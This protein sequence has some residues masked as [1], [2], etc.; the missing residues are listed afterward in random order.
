M[1][2]HYARQIEKLKRMILSLGKRVEE[3]VQQAIQAIEQR[4]VDLARAVIE[5]DA[6]IDEQEV[7]IEEECLHTLALY[8]PVASDMRFIV[9]VVKINN[10]LERIGDHAA[11]LAEQAIF[12]AREPRIDSVPFDF[13]GECRRVLSMVHRSLTALVSGDA[14][15]ALRVRQDDDEVDEIH[16]RMYQQVVGAIQEDA[17]DAHRLIGLMNASRQLERIADLAVN[18]AEDVVYLVKGEILRHTEEGADALQVAAT[19]REPV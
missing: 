11:N 8:Q 14:Q 15:L 13:G 12:L 9:S 2:Q 19:N 6:A 10:D 18:I 5:R 3:S 4:D 1:L 16:R 17:D 7:D